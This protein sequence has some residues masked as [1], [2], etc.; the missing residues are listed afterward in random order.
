[1]QIYKQVFKNQRKNLV[2]EYLMDSILQKSKK[3]HPLQKIKI[4]ESCKIQ[5][6]ENKFS[7]IH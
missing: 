4:N 7:P 2:K 5:K 6:N 1:M 3:T